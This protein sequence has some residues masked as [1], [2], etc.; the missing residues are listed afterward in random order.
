MQ[1]LQPS[2]PS[3]SKAERVSDGIVHVL[4]LVLAVAAV[5]ALIIATA[6]SRPGSHAIWGVSIYGGALLL[7]LTFSALNN[8]VTAQRWA[9]LL[10]RLDHSAIYI[11][12]AGTYTPFL[13]MSGA[14]ISAML[15]GLWGSAAIG[16]ILKLVNPERFRWLGLALYLGMG[17]AVLVVG[18]PVFAALSGPTITLMIAGG[19]VYTVGVGFFLSERLRFHNT[20][21]HVFVL[22]GCVLFYIAV[23]LCIAG[24]AAPLSSG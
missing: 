15:A 17:W 12:I 14:Q 7:L 3:Y 2:R 19:V 16:S 1:Q 23:A 11:K 8:M 5:P 6:M 21:W 22:A 24:H 4:G 20:I 18:G 13:L 10:R 9:G